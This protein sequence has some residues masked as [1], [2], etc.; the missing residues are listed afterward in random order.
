MVAPELDGLMNLMKR[1]VYSVLILVASLGAGCQPGVHS[2]DH[3][4][5]APH[6]R[7]GF[8][9]DDVAKLASAAAAKPYESPERPM[10]PGTE[11]FTYDDFRTL[12]CVM[13]HA[14]WNEAAT[15]FSLRYAPRGWLFKVPVD[16]NLIRPDGSVQN[17]P[18][19]SEYFRFDIKGRPKPPE[20]LGF[21]GLKINHESKKGE[22]PELATFLGASYFRALA[23]GQVYGA[24]ARSLAIDTGSDH[25]EFPMLTRFWVKEPAAGDR[26]IEVLGLMDSP[27]VVGA[28]RY[29]ITP[30]EDTVVTVR[31]RLFARKDVAKLGL[32]PITS[33]FLFGKRSDRRFPDDFR[34]EVHDSDGLLIHEGVKDI[35]TWRPLNNPKNLRTIVH[36]VKQLRGFGLLQRD[37]DYDHYLDLEANY[38]KRPSV[39]VEPLS[40]WGAGNVELFELASELEYNDNANA[41]WVP[42]QPLKAGQKLEL[43]YAVHWISGDVPAE[44]VGRVIATYRQPLRESKDGREGKDSGRLRYL[45]DFQGPALAALAADAKIELWINPK[46]G[47]KV[48]A[49]RTQYNP[50]TRG[51]RLVFEFDP[52]GL[53]TVELEAGLA[54][55]GRNLTETW[56]ERWDR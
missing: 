54:I 41:Y 35:W 12:I 15:R 33:M 32:A 44:Q 10:P 11:K 2:T 22:W 13:A 55:G 26:A 49:A 50:H 29:L 36:P 40:D 24:S 23:P 30:G 47:G 51:W 37:V 31:A 21:A 9:F 53:N 38:D 39:W 3:P 43:D 20:G 18:Y 17:V 8:S 46:G 34:P 14:P 48:V 6:P 42:A 45:V 28:Y 4:G 27:S 16:I 7:A 1:S 19:D 52:Q 25:E 56:S 5:E